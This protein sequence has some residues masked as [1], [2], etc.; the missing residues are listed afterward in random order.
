MTRNQPVSSFLLPQLS[1]IQSWGHLS[2]FVDVFYIDISR[3]A[4]YLLLLYNNLYTK[5]ILLLPASPAS[6]TPDLR[7]ILLL[8]CVG[9]L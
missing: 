2:L 8:L 3:D 7:R 5:L 6:E 9:L 4:F 1:I